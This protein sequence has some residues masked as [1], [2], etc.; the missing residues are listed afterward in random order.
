MLA[1]FCLIAAPVIWAQVKKPTPAVA[2]RIAALSWLTGTWRLEKNGRVVDEQW[3]VPAGGVMPGMSRALNKGR[4]GEIEFFQI[5]EGPGGD[6]F[7][8]RHLTGTQPITFKSVSLTATEVVFA[9]Q[10]QDFPQTIVLS[11]RPDGSLARVS[12]G[13]GT[14]GQER[15]VEELFRRVVP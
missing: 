6:L 4:A 5:R 2:G 12:A 3:M 8:I 1:G 15:T 11:L 9:N 10:L 14:D 7:Y 13:P